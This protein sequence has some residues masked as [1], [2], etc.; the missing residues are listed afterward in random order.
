[1][2]SSPWKYFFLH[3]LGRSFHIWWQIEVALNG[4]NFPKWLP[5]WCQNNFWTRK[6]I[7]IMSGSWKMHNTKGYILSFWSTFYIKKLRSYG[8]FKIWPIFGPDDVI[9]DVINTKNYTDLARYKIHIPVKFGVDCSNG[10]TCIVNIT[11]KQTD[12]RAIGDCILAKICYYNAHCNGDSEN[13]SIVDYID[14]WLVWKSIGLHVLADD[15]NAL[16]LFFTHSTCLVTWWPSYW[17]FELE[18]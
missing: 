11:D 2:T 15:A 7:K 5:D 18:N 8:N 9:N 14:V 1:M 6:D 10:A 16:Y 13:W 3:N 4:L 17:T 12:E